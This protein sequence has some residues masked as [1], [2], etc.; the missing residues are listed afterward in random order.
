[1]TAATRN[2][3]SVD[4]QALG[5]FPL[6]LGLEDKPFE[7]SCICGSLYTLTALYI[8]CVCMPVE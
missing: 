2:L 7:L 4:L 3:V 1:M 6:G 8:V 5:Q